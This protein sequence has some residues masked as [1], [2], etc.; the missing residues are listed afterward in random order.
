MFLVYHLEKDNWI[1]GGP[2]EKKG[3][4]GDVAACVYL[5]S[6]STR[7]MLN[8][9]RQKYYFPFSI[10]SSFVMAHAF[11]YHFRLFAS[12]D[13]LGLS[14]CC[15]HLKFP[16]APFSLM[17]IGILKIEIMIYYIQLLYCSFMGVNPFIQLRYCSFVGLNPF[18]NYDDKDVIF[19]S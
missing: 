5:S 8:S 9:H 10:S 1:V 15:V 17:I 7:R 3:G 6:S 11:H 12:H 16:V 14:T 2:Q 19:C 18:M 4:R 13:W